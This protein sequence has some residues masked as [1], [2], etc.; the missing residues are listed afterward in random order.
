M[1]ACLNYYFSLNDLFVKFI[2][3]INMTDGTFKTAR[4]E[5]ITETSTVKLQNGGG[6]LLD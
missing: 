6:D 4:E 5:L 1:P 3:E 2:Q